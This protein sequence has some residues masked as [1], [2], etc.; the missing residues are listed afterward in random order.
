[1][2]QGQWICLFWLAEVLVD[3]PPTADQDLPMEQVEVVL[4]ILL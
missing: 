4:D 2:D 3:K 1:V